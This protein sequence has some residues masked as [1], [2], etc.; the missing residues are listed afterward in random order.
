M[1]ACVAAPSAVLGGRRAAAISRRSAATQFRGLQQRQQRASGGDLAAGAAAGA[2]RC[3][4]ACCCAEGPA[5]GLWVF[6]QTL[7]CVPTSPSFCFLTGMWQSSSSRS[8]AAASSRRAAP[9]EAA[10]AAGA[11]SP[12]VVLTREQGKNGKLRR[13]LEGR[14]ISCLE[15]PMVETAAGPDRQRLPQVHTRWRVA[16]RCCGG[17]ERPPQLPA[18]NPVLVLRCRRCHLPCILRA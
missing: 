1:S 11:G 5:H 18:V 9:A 10:A 2:P 7:P 13:V 17:L 3:P 4:A 6:R 8:S 15:L 16:L 12:Q 14:G